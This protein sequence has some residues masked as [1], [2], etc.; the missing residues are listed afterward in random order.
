[1][2]LEIY[3]DRPER[4]RSCAACN[5]TWLE[6]GSPP[7]HSC[8]TAPATPRTTLAERARVAN[9]VL[10]DRELEIRKTRLAEINRARV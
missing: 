5:W 4:Q 8:R 6:E 9:R 7:P 3:T 10:L 2:D 1:M